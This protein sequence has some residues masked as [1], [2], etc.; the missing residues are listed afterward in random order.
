MNKELMIYNLKTDLERYGVASDL[1]DLEALI[2][3]N[4]TYPENL[5]LIHEYIGEQSHKQGK[6]EGEAINQQQQEHAFGE[7]V[8]EKLSLSELFKKYNVIGL[9]GNRNTG[10]TMLILS[11]LVELKKEHPKT[12]VFVFG[13]EESLKKTL[14]SK[15]IEW[16]YSKQDILD[17]KIRDSVIYIDEFA[18]FFSM[19]VRDRETEQLKHFFNRVNHLN[20]FVVIGTAET[21]FWNKFACSLV[22]CMLVKRIEFDSLTNGTWLKR[23]VMGLERT[24][25]YRLD[26]DKNEYF[27]LS[28]ELTQKKTFEYFSELDSKKNKVNPFEVVK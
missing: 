23:L 1:V 21:G 3:S 20:D 12:R 2:D 13:I 19:Q 6:K 26:I 4:L 10:K 5:K 18:S 9:A 28:E 8:K 14:K 15:G 11:Q 27:V 22:N 25:D 17:L 7:Q 16:L 24:S